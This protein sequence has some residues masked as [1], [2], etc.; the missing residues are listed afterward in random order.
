MVGRGRSVIP[1]TNRERESVKMTANTKAVDPHQ[2]DEDPEQLLGEEIPDPW[3][4]EAQ[5]DWA[6]N[7]DDPEVND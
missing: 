6:V 2:V 7:E 4:D 3:L 1:P 5:T